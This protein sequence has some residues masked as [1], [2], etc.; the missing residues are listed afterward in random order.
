MRVKNLINLSVLVILLQFTSVSPAL[1]AF[2]MMSSGQPIPFSMIDS[3]ECFSL[4]QKLDLKIL[5]LRNKK[6]MKNHARA[7]IYEFFTS[8][9]FLDPDYFK[10][11]YSSNAP[12]K[13]QYDTDKKVKLLFTKAIHR[14]EN[15][16]LARV[17]EYFKIKPLKKD[18]ISKKWRDSFVVLEKLEDFNLKYLSE[19]KAKSGSIDYKILKFTFANKHPHHYEFRTDTS[20]DVIRKLKKGT[21]TFISTIQVLCSPNRL[22]PENR[23]CAI[24]NI[25]L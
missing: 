21:T 8:M 18:S 20:G 11:I 2:V 9:F 14:I 12:I 22:L 7:I 6:T 3:P 13:K 4:S 10:E 25:E 19:E 1:S 5:K 16:Y 17:Y 24:W 23:N 15:H